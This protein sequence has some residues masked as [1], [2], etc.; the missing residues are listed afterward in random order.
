MQVWEHCFHHV[1]CS[2]V[3]QLQLHV[4][5]RL[6]GNELLVGLPLRVDIRGD[7]SFPNSSLTNSCLCRSFFSIM[8]QACRNG[9]I[10]PGKFLRSKMLIADTTSLEEAKWLE[11]L[12]FR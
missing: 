7:N 3:L 8:C 5:F 2:Q 9:F 6:Y 4:M 1:V 12:F 10:S 11:I